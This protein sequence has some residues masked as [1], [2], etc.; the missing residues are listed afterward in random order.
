MT[1]AVQFAN[2]PA[3]QLSFAGKPRPIRPKVR[4]ASGARR[5]MRDTV[6][7]GNKLLA[8][9]ALEFQR[10]LRSARFDFL[11]QARA[12]FLLGRASEETFFIRI[13]KL[14]THWRRTAEILA[15]SRILGR[16]RIRE[17]ARL[18]QEESIE[19][20]EIFAEVFPSGV[21]PTDAVRYIRSLPVVTPDQWE[22]FIQQHGRAAFTISGVEQR[23][24]IRSL[25]DLIATS[26]ESGLTPVQFDRQAGE[27]LRNFERIGPRRLNTLYRTTVGNALTRGR[28]EQLSDPAVRRV[29][30]H[31]LFDAMIDAAV[32]P[33]HAALEGGIAPW[34]WWEGPGRAFK[35]KLG[36]NCRCELIGLTS[37]RARRIIGG[38][39]GFDLTEVIP[40][41]AGPDSGWTRVN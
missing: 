15:A 37:V 4:I 13:E 30:T 25:R 29:L 1:G 39:Q 8:A 22:A 21:V 26:L 23:Q 38:T 20:R 18:A 36:F 7:D 28:E 10:F 35:P 17:E 2:P 5:E 32:R 41:G 14:R 34:E 16:L 11:A 31:R 24:V 6:R 27:L 33:N 3:P 40:T 19:E 12:G 9:S